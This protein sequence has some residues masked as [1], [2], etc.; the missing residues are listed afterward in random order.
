MHHVFLPGL[1]SGSHLGG[2]RQQQQ[3]GL[4][5]LSP[6][7][8]SAAT[9]YDSALS[10]AAA[11]QNIRNLPGDAGP[12][13]CPGEAIYVSNSMTCVFGQTPPS[14]S[15]T[16]FARTASG[17]SLP[18]RTIAGASTGL[19][20]TGPIGIAVDT[21]N[22][23]ILV[24]FSGTIA[25]FAR[26]GS[27]NVAP[28]RTISGPSTGLGT[29]AL[30]IAVDT[31]NDEIDVIDSVTGSIAVFARTASGDVAPLRTIS[32]PSTGI[33]DANN[34]AVDTVNNELDVANGSS[35]LVFSR[36]A[37]GNV[38]PLRTIASVV[39]S[40]DG[41]AVDTVNNEIFVL[42]ESTLALMI[43]VTVYA[44]TALSDAGP[45]RTL[46]GLLTGVSRDPTGIAVD[47]ANNELV[48]V[49]QNSGFGI[50]DTL[51]VFARTASGNV[52]PLRTLSGSTGV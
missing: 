24:T 5:N 9:P 46:S 48:V 33:E 34:L 38:G 31:V 25:A 17:E 52:A 11:Q 35:I 44:R 27:G 4:Q 42:G 23:E 15:I 6:I 12:V 36:T 29:G 37:S 32:G 2:Q 26:L 20:T 13:A 28:L 14:G 19:G 49:N 22:N 47:P 40:Q 3:P 51:E 41:I 16:V 7:A 39:L 1:L 10:G 45:L 50:P 8:G 30:G 21:L 43:G 18:L